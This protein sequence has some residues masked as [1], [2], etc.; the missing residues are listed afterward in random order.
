[1]LKLHEE[2][3]VTSMGAKGDGIARRDG[4][5]IHIPFTL[6]NETIIAIVD[7]E[8]GELSELITPSPERVAP[9]C[10]WFGT[11]GGC[12]LQHWAT[13]PYTQWKRSLLGQALLQQGVE[14]T[15]KPMV[16][17]YGAGRR[18]VVF[19][20]R[21]KEGR[22]EIGFMARRTH[23]LIPIDHCPILVPALKDAPALAHHI[24][25]VIDT[26]KP[27]DLHITATDTGLDCDIRGL[28]A[29]SDRQRRRLVENFASFHLARL[30]VHGALIALRNEPSLSL[31]RATIALPSGA[32]LQ[33]TS[34]AEKALTE[35]AANFLAPAKKI[36]DLFCGIGPF[37][38]RLAEKA[39]IFA[40]DSDAKAIEALSAVRAEGLKPI[41]ATMRDLFRVPLVPTELNQ[42]DAVL[43]DPPRAGA[44]AQME[45]LAKSDVPRIVSVACDIQSFARDAKIL[46]QAG[47][48]CEQVIPVDQ[49]AF[50]AHL[51]MIA[52]FTKTIPSSRK[53]RILG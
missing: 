24:A 16:T 36:A 21:K 10:R 9:S 51:E 46:T 41:K 17:A 13:E 26:D 53:R 25:S 7:E 28:G 37:A 47:Y 15:I 22:V 14:T 48:V 20:A 2:L 42:F 52:L 29:P 3:I 43:L 40:Y 23:Q 39:S 27:L 18:R 30:S 12:A 1:M 32:F 35:I 38:I 19:H 49:F 33:A 8:R 45:Q 11:C 31:G 5:I 50:S 4:R 44:R 6:P 34:E